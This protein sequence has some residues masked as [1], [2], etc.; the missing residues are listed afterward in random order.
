MTVTVKKALCLRANR[1][2]T[3]KSHEYKKVDSRTIRFEVKVPKDKETV[4]TYT[5]HYP[6]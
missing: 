1:E 3:A 5:V 4:V 6:W 2:T